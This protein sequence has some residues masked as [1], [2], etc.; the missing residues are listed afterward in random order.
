MQVVSASNLDPTAPYNDPAAVLN[1]PTCSF[2]IPWRRVTDRVSIIDDP[3]NVTP[4]GGAVI[5]EIKTGGQIT[6]N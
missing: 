5:A 4:K 1:R 6:V 3:Y 2:S